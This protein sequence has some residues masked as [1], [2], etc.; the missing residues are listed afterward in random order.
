MD[1]A[2]IGIERT[3]KLDGNNEKSSELNLRIG[4]EASAGLGRPEDEVGFC[5]GCKM[6]YNV[7]GLDYEL[8]VYERQDKNAISRTG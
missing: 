2:L 3:E 1:A 7:E 5:E 8:L 4:Q 6:L